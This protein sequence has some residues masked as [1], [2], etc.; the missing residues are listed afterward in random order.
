MRSQ[1]GGVFPW[2]LQ[3]S[4]VTYK[5][6]D[7]KSSRFFTD[8]M[9]F[10]SACEPPYGSVYPSPIILSSFTI[11]QPPLGWVQLFQSFFCDFN[12]AFYIC[13]IRKN[14]VF[15]FVN[16]CVFET[17]I[18]FIKRMSEFLIRKIKKQ[19]NPQMESVIRSVFF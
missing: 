14:D 8:L 10:T 12:A 5:V 18:R 4:R 7:F 6:A 16:I 17:K 19:D 2:W 11:K 3:G 15:C 13:R 1:Q 9:A